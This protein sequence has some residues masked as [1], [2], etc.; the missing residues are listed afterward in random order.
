MM[1]TRE[2]KEFDCVKTTREIRD[3]LSVE[4]AGMSLK[5]ESSGSI[6]G[7]SR[8]RSCAAS[9]T[10]CGHRKVETASPLRRARPAAPCPDAIPS[11]S[12]QEASDDEHRLH[13]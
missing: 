1:T 6:A 7:I 11:V 9:S 12:R 4:L 10:G 8:T 5:T 13:S 2:K 3:R